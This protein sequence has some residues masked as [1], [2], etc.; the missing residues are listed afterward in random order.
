MKG[1]IPLGRWAG[2]PVGAHWSALLAVAL[3]AQAVAASV[4]PAAA[5]GRSA[6]VYWVVGVVVA[7]A[8]FASL[9]AHELA[10]TVVARRHGVGVRRIDLWLLG[11]VSQL[12]S[13]PPTPRADFLISVAG[14]AT[15]AA[16]AVG[17][18]GVAV[19]VDA[20]GGGLLA[21]TAVLWLA[22]TNAVL[23]VFNLV[24]AAPLDG[25][26]VLRAAVWWRTGS[27]ARGERAATDAGRGF[28]F[29]LLVAGLA[30]VVTGAAAGVW[31]LLMGAFVVAA[32][33]AERRHAVVREA[34]GG[35]P[36]RDA[37]RPDPA[38][39]P[40]WWTVQ[41]FLERRAGRAATR[42]PGRVVRRRRGGRDQPG[43]TDR[44]TGTTTP[45][46][47]NSR[48]LPPADRH[49]RPRR[50]AGRGPDPRLANPGTRRRGGPAGR[51]RA[52]PDHNRRRRPRGGTGTRR[53]LTVHSGCLESIMTRLLRYAAAIATLLALATPTAPAHAT[54]PSTTSITPT[55]AGTPEV[56]SVAQEVPDLQLAVWFDKPSYLGHEFVTVHARVTNAGTAAARAAVSSTGNLSSRMWDPQDT[57]VEPGHSAEFTNR[58]IV[59]TRE[60]LSITVT[61][62]GRDGE[63]DA[64][65]A[66]NTVT[67]TVPV[68]FVR[69]TYRGTVHGDRDGDKTA[70]PGEALAGL[71]VTATGGNPYT[72]YDAVT[73]TEGRFVFTDLP[74]GTYSTTLDT[75]EWY[76]RPFN[77]EVDGTD[78]PD[79]AILAVPAI[80]P[81]VLTV[82][83][84]FTQPSYRVDDVARLDVTPANT[85]STVL[86]DVAAD[87]RASGSGEVDRGELGTGVTLAPGAT[88]TYAMTVRITPEAATEGHLRLDC[89]LGAPP[90]SN[91]HVA[92]T[93]VARV[94]G[95]LAPR[96]VGYLGLFRS[97]PLLG[98]PNSEP[99][100]GVKVYLRDQVTGTVVTRAVTE[101]NGSFTFLDVP[102]GLYDFGVVGPWRLVHSD[103][104][105]IVRDGEDG[106]AFLRHWYYVVP[107]PD[108]PDPD[109][110]PTATPAPPH[111]RPPLAATGTGITW[112]ATSGLLT[113]AAGATLLHLTGRRTRH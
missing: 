9:A 26:R 27:R 87:C 60:D 88:G 79:V 98:P 13:R 99:L 22:F 84:A 36:V 38:V 46:H 33:G 73:D 1:R 83:A 34:L 32:A 4:L 94:P 102:A 97:K 68:T 111:H 65:P 24:P 66:D 67:A 80:R 30:L 100:P 108:Q 11:G 42:L 47:P 35:L 10:H 55:T 45:D 75:Q 51:P 64:N 62:A 89:A 113:L 29:V 39:A 15:S 2:V 106:P 8:F 86:T 52:G 70:D 63:P 54:T 58:G 37:M 12:T 96:V 82:T 104:R 5:P 3:V 6:A 19:L 61:V 56:P 101:A 85:G 49:R 91:G 18:T 109:P 92:F 76:A 95:G 31:W 16:V 40:G 72:S 57:V 48:H 103:P 110:P 53:H 78:D 41:G 90:G 21:T 71:Q 93:A 81:E 69:G 20:V 107:G 14:P 43:R 25:G 59:T 23:A 105:F 17:A 28:G 50:A 7:V 44:T 112:L 74:G 77:V